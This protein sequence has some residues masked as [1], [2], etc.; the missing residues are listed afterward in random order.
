MCLE[1]DE[2]PSWR[3]LL[4]MCRNLSFILWSREAIEEFDEVSSIDNYLVVHIIL[5]I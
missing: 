5:T 1:K 4:A 3:P 2:S